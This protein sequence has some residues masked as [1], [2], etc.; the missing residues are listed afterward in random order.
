MLFR[1][2]AVLREHASPDNW[3]ALIS[4]RWDED[5]TWRFAG[6]LLR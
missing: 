4:F 3:A 5:R 1:E 6:Y 2:I